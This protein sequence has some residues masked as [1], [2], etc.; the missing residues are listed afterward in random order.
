MI[1]PPKEFTL[2][3]L[4]EEVV[5]IGVEKRQFLATKLEKHK[6][7]TEFAALEE[8]RLERLKALAEYLKG[9]LRQSNPKI[10]SAETPTE[11]EF[12]PYPRLDVPAQAVDDMR[13]G[14]L[15]AEIA[16]PAQ[17]IDDFDD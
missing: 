10:S 5:T 3:E 12:D 1:E 6:I 15:S 2:K 9:Q 17:E 8:L 14:T 13:T 16:A 7:S 4:F 11:P